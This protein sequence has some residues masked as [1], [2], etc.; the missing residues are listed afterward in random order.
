MAIS[1]TD[2]DARRALVAEEAWEA[3]R[4]ERRAAARKVAPRVFSGGTVPEAALPGPE[5]DRQAPDETAAELA[6]DPSTEAAAADDRSE[7]FGRLV[8]ALLALP[9]TKG[10]ELGASARA[11]AASF[12]LPESEGPRAADLVARARKRPEIAAA[13]K[14]DAVY[15]DLPFAVPLDGELATGRIDLAYR[16][17]PAWTLIDFKTAGFTD[18]AQALAAHGA[19][20]T[21]SAAAL[22]LVTGA[23]TPR[24][25]FLLADGELV[26]V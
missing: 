21:A 6:A 8:H 4:K 1:G 26:G 22:A 14:A 17:G 16:K 7:A 5:P 20:L 12:G 11:L 13:G 2:A 10:R 23:R 9:D 15:R 25:L 18:A 3:E 19:R 24:A